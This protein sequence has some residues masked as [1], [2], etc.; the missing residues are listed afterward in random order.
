[1]DT[2]IFFIVLV[3]AFTHALWNFAAKK[4]SGNFTVFWYG[5]Y[6]VSILQFTFT[7]YLLA[8]R[9]FNSEGL[10]FLLISALAHFFYNMAFLYTYSKS[11][12]SSVYPIS[13]GTGVA[14]TALFSYFLFHETISLFAAIGIASVFTGIMFIGFSSFRGQRLDKKTFLVALLSGVTIVIYSLTDKHGVAHINP[15]VYINLIN[16]INLTAL[17]PIAIFV[18]SGGIK[19][20]FA[21]FKANF[22]YAMIIGF[23][24]VGTYLIILYAMTLERASYIVSLREFSV[25][26][27]SFLGFVFL[28]EKPTALKIIGIL[29]VTAGLI[30]IKTG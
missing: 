16:L 12:I 17:A 11:D 25:V 13:R 15:A 21:V 30:F 2:L 6:S 23:G 20:S 10:P 28:K 4:I 5:Q 19:K 29:C 24:S 1:M 18:N 8:T 22:R 26:I 7:G 14:G 3:A 27:G 9:G